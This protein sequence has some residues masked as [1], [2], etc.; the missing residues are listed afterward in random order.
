MEINEMFL[1]LV[2]DSFKV[3]SERNGF[4]S[5]WRWTRHFLYS[6]M[7]IALEN[8]W[9]FIPFYEELQGIASQSVTSGY[10]II[11]KEWF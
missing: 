9:V 10:E 4:L 2:V 8:S 11:C 5:L 3:E 7:F 1:N 6:S